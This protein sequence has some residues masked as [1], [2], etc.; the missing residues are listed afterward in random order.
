MTR[1]HL[2][3]GAPTSFQSLSRKGH[4]VNLI[5]GWDPFVTSLVLPGIERAD[6]AGKTSDHFKLLCILPT[7]TA[8]T[9]EFAFLPSSPIRKAS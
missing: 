4:R 3:T 9:C 8:S 5:A 6:P 7:V 2:L 1:G